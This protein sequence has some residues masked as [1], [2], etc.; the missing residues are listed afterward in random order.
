MIYVTYLQ[1]HNY[2]GYGDSTMSNYSKEDGSNL[3][4]NLSDF[5][6]MTRFDGRFFPYSQAGSYF[7][8]GDIS[9]PEC[10]QKIVY[11]LEGGKY[12]V[13]DF[14]DNQYGQYFY[15]YALKEGWYINYMGQIYDYQGNIVE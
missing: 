7:H 11:K 10:L 12:T 5:Y 3:G 8:N 13:Q 1:V 2:S 15:V 4:Q 9:L 14:N 6:I